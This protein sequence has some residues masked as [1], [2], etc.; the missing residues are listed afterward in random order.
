MEDENQNGVKRAAIRKMFQELGITD[1]QLPIEEFTFLTKI[2]YKAPSD[3]MWGEHEGI[4][5]DCF[6][7]L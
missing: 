2:L 1:D 6:Y 4:L 5:E 7:I 3:G